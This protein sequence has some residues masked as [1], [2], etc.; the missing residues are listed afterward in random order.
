MPNISA[1]DGLKIVILHQRLLSERNVKK[2]GEVEDKKGVEGQE[3]F[4]NLMSHFSERAEEDQQELTQH[5][6][7]SAGHQQSEEARSGI[8]LVPRNLLVQKG[9]RNLFLYFLLL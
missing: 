7:A 2:S 3:N 8:V 9:G 5:L 4:Q 6:A 1:S